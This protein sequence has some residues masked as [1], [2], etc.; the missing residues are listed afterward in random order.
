MIV[1]PQLLTPG[2][3]QA[4]VPLPSRK[5]ALQFLA[6]MLAEADCTEDQIFD[7][8]MNRER[9]GSTGL[10]SGVAVPHCRL[11]C[12]GMKMAFISLE[13]P[14]NYE[15]SDGEPVDLLFTLVVPEDEQTA[16]LEM[17]A[18]LAETFSDQ[19]NRQA[20]RNCDS[21]AELFSKISEL[22]HRA[23]GAK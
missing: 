18:L 22:L 2:V 4:K 10:G 17:L 15:A 1:S 9:L 14:L 8:L 16:H 13:Q 6:E 19:T 7:E 12:A 20:L 21:D 23:G 11:P 5:R 3:V